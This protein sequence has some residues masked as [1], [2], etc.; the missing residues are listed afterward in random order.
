MSA[1]RSG[2]KQTSATK[3]NVIQCV[4]YFALIL[5]FKLKKVENNARRNLENIK[6]W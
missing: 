3:T 4:F 2:I 5:N 1:S 6:G